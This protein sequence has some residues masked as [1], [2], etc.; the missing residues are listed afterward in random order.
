MDESAFRPGGV[1]MC[2]G[3]PAAMIF[4]QP[5][6][7]IR[8]TGRDLDISLA[9]ICMEDI[10]IIEKLLAKMRTSVSASE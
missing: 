2:D 1:I 8:V 7:T 6:Y 10:E 9:V 3:P 5:P 4:R